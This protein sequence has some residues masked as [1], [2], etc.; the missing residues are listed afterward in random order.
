MYANTW[1][2]YVRI[3]MRSRE[4]ISILCACAWLAHLLAMGA[5]TLRLPKREQAIGKKWDE[6]NLPANQYGFTTEI[7]FYFRNS[8]GAHCIPTIVFVFQMDK[9]V[10]FSFTWRQTDVNWTI[11]MCFPESWNEG[12]GR[13]RGLEDERR[14]IS[15]IW[16]WKFL[17]WDFSSAAHFLA[18]PS[19][20]TRAAI[21]TFWKTKKEKKMAKAEF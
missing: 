15:W 13:F 11:R 18:F 8:T 3:G 7:G 5:I 4:T 10:F 17:F 1:C 19:Y 16:L 14:K 6:P 12:G 21:E 20:F 2:A 9:P